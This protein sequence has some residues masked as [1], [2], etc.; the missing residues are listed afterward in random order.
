MTPRIQALLL[1]ALLASV[2]AAKLAQADLVMV[3]GKVAMRESST[4]RPTRGMT[5][6]QVEERF[7]APAQRRGTVGQPPITR[8]DYAEFSVY[9]EHERVLHAVA[10]GA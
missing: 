8:W 1:A 3:D 7:G 4:Q 6:R 10:S 5:M 9:F 2:G